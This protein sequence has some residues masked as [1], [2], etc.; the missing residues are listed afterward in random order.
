MLEFFRSG[1]ETDPNTSVLAGITDPY[2][3]FICLAEDF[4]KS[5][6]S[7]VLPR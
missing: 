7:V 5:P 6:D 1:D 2:G 4:I 3:K